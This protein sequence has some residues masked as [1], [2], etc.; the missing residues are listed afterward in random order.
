VRRNNDRLIR[1]SKEVFE[2]G[3]TIAVPGKY[4]VNQLPWLK[5]VPGWM[6]F[7]GFKQVGRRIR[8]QLL[9]LME[10]PFSESLKRMV[11][12][13]SVVETFSLSMLRNLEIF[14]NAL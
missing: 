9:N 8:G 6:P 13:T 11:S 3:N 1:Q 12:F 10:R 5:Y 7:T 2:I 4:L 14:A